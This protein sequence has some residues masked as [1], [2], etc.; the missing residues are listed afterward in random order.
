MQVWLKNRE[1]IKAQCVQGYV[2]LTWTSAPPPSET[3]IHRN[4]R[5]LAREEWEKQPG[6]EVAGSKSTSFQGATTFSSQEV[7]DGIFDGKIKLYLFVMAKWQT[8]SGKRVS[9]EIDEMFELKVPPSR[10]FDPRD[11]QWQS[12]GAAPM[13]A[14]STAAQIR[15]IDELRESGRQMLDAPAGK[16]PPQDQVNSICAPIFQ[17]TSTNLT[18]G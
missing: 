17:S 6:V 16:L 5:K 10:K 14:Q 4:V 13:P 1:P 9:Q 8:P 12:C 18:K 7:I 11:L 15:T 2:S 3:R